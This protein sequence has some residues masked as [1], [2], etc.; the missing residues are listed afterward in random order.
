MDSQVANLFMPLLS[1][2]SDFHSSGLLICQLPADDTSLEAECLASTGTMPDLA[3]LRLPLRRRQRLAQHL[4]LHHIAPGAGLLI[5]S[6]GKPYLENGPYLSFSHSGDLVGLITSPHPVGLDIQTPDERLV[7]LA[8]RFAGPEERAESGEDLLALTT[9]WSTK[10]AIF[11]VF[12]EGVEFARD[13]RVRPFTSDDSL[14]LADYR[15]HHGSVTFSLRRFWLRG[16]CVVFT[17]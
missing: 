12:G 14:L 13:V 5:H 11:K 3:G 8:H 2:P 16:A 4:L 10:E 15:G 7:R 17:L 6:N 1:I 9:I